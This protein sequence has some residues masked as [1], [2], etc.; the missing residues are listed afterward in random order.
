VQLL[1][2]KLVSLGS[3]SEGLEKV[4]NALGYVFWESF[5]TESGTDN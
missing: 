5:G 3:T 1:S 2:P 4:E